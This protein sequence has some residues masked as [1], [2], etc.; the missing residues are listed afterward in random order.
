MRPSLYALTFALAAAL[1]GAA[2]AQPWPSKPVRLIVSFPPGSGADIVARIIAPRL[3]DAFAQQFI[4]DNR[5]GAAGHIGAELAARAAPDGYT[6]LFTPASIAV[7]LAL[8][9]KLNYDP[10]KDLEPVALAASAPFVLVVHPSLPVR[11]VTELIALAKAKP[12]QLLY[13]STGNGG[14]PHLATEMFRRETGI[15]IVHVPYKGTPA[16]ITDLLGGQ[17]QLMFGNALSV[18][19]LVQGGRLRALAISSAKRSAAAPQLPTL[20]ESGLPRYEAGT[21]FGLLAPTGTGADIIARLSGEVIKIV[22]MPTVRGQLLAQGA[23][24]IG[25]P[26][27]RFR[28]YLKAEIAK[29]AQVVKAT[30]ARVD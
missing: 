2:I 28:T 13:A 21:W 5:A 24:P 6:F 20:A 15:D 8:Y 25:M 29:W 10:E 26:P 11:S 22:H 14:S 19:P 9:S 18:L 16:A 12:G 1:S 23:D 27:D 4:I 17:V 30:G 7:S 3:A